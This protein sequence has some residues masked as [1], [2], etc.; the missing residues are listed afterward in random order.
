MG[1]ENFYQ[2]VDR[3]VVDPMLQMSWKAFLR[4]YPWRRD[5]LEELLAFAVEPEPDSGAVSYILAERSLRWTMKRSTPA[6]YFLNV[7]IYHVP[8]LKR[9]CPEIWLRKNSLEVAVIEATAVEAFLDDR[10]GEHMLWAVYNIDGRQNPTEWL[11]LSGSE[12]TRVEIGLGF[13]AVEKPI[14]PWQTDDCLD[15]G[16][17]CLRLAD[18]KRFIAFLTQAWRENWPVPRLSDDV[19]KSLAIVDEATPH[20]RD[21]ELPRRLVT[22]VN[23]TRLDRPCALHYFG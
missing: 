19:R 13:A 9:R 20:F 15:D 1:I 21:F 22:C 17:R 11:K 2:F 18:T 3:A 4:K 8:H 6:Y 5:S 12:L 16:Y 7:L 14:F 23:A 10:I